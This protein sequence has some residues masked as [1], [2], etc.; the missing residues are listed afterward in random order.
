M[1]KLR[2]HAF[3]ISVDGYGAGP[4]QDLANPLGVGG[5]A[6][7]EWAFATHTFKRM[8][9]RRGRHD[10]HRRRFRVPRVCRYRSMDSWAQHVRAGARAVARSNVERVVGRQSSVSHS[11]LRAHA[12]SAPV[13]RHGRRYG[14]PLHHR[15]HSRGIGS[16]DALR[17]RARMSDSAAESP[18]S[19][20]ICRAGADR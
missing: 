20:N 11:G 16:R 6:L 10:R 2:V 18:P 7:H 9:R 17:P 14:L 1:V 5:M 8:Y 12:P 19:G 4:G 3:S 13:D 15:R